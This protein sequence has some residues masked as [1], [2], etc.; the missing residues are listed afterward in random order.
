MFPQPRTTSS[1]FPV[2]LAQWFQ[3]RVGIKWSGT[4]KKKITHVWTP[5]PAILIKLSA[6]Q[7][8]VFSES[9][10][11]IQMCTLMWSK[12]DDDQR[13][14]ASPLSR[15]SWHFLLT[16]Y[17]W[18]LD[19]SCFP[20]DSCLVLLSNRLVLK[21]RLPKETANARVGRSQ[22]QTSLHP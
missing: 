13:A 1:I 18:W 6:A 5:P 21:A 3:L 15:I 17:N 8:L 19:A 7:V 16:S 11:V 14:M 22:L 2:H 9:A 20:S 10:Q 12:T 4:R